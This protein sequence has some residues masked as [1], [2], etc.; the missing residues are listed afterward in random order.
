MLVFFSPLDPRHWRVFPCLWPSYCCTCDTQSDLEIENDADWPFAASFFSLL[1]HL[2]CSFF[3]WGGQLWTESANR[4][5]LSFVRSFSYV[6]MRLTEW[7]IKSVCQ[8]ILTFGRVGRKSINFC[9]H[10]SHKEK[11]E[12]LAA[13]TRP[14]CGSESEFVK[15]FH[16]EK[17]D[18]NRA[19]C[20]CEEMRKNLR[21][22]YLNPEINPKNLNAYTLSP[23]PIFFEIPESSVCVVMFVFSRKFS[24]SWIFSH[25]IEQTWGLSE[26]WEISHLHCYFC[27]LCAIGGTFDCFFS[28]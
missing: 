14:Q 20:G 3:F 17:D 27:L 18:K 6:L 13:V 26:I 11:R 28:T 15:D 1:L 22:E 5:L 12:E 21:S 2:C 7:R 25:E 16:Q 9:S 24:W 8:N 4:H 10:G 23:R 19:Q